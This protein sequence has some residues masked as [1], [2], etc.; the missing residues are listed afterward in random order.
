MVLVS[1][2]GHFFMFFQLI[3]NGNSIIIYIHVLMVDLGFG[4]C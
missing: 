1:D 3:L 2:A 4:I